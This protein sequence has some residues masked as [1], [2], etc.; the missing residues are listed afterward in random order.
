[1]I[2]LLNIM[3]RARKASTPKVGADA[4]L[5]PIALGRRFYQ[6]AVARTAEVN[7]P[8]GLR[9]L[10]FGVLVRLHDTP[11]LDQN[12]LAERMALDRTTAG[13]MVQ[14]LEELGLVER[15]VNGRDRRARVLRLSPAGRALHDRQRPAAVAAQLRMLEVLSPAE[16]ASLIDMLARVVEANQAYVRPGAGRRPRNARRPASLESTRAK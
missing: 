16:R 9:P 7:E 4:A 8:H 14:H 15:T 5:S 10:E 3:T 12:S 1:M 2:R 11:G 6:I 13:A